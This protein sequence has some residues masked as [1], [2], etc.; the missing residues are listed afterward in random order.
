MSQEKISAVLCDHYTKPVVNHDT[1]PNAHKQFFAGLRGPTGERGCTGPRG[2]CGKTG[3]RG[4]TGPAAR[5]RAHEA[6]YLYGTFNR[7]GY[8][9][10]YVLTGPLNAIDLNDLHVISKT[11]DIDVVY[12]AEPEI[13][14]I[15]FRSAGVYAVQVCLSP[16]LPA[17]EHVLILDTATSEVAAD[18][19]SVPGAFGFVDT[20]RH[21]SITLALRVKEKK[22]WKIDAANCTLAV[23]RI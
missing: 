16:P 23:F 7:H 15:R 14:H 4:P 20:R 13:A 8:T 18:I 3:E 9:S 21:R 5:S 1:F 2:P 10:E 22:L 12:P 6:S 19:G 17:Y 11:P